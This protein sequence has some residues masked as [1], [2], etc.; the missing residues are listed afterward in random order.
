[1]KQTT[2]RKITNHEGVSV[3][4]TFTVDFGNASPEQMAEWA[5]SNRVI[6]GQKVWR[7][8]S[9]EELQDSVNG[10]T[11]D[12]RHIGKGIE[13]RA[14]QLKALQDKLGVSEKVAELILDNPGEL[15]AM[16]DKSKKDK[17]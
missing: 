3:T 13:S 16:V 14:K 17:K 11:F 8:L 9:A 2:T 10:K 15:E 6:A 4:V 7:N 5:L 12:A 1:M